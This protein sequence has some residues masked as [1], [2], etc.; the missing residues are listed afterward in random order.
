MPARKTLLYPLV[1]FPGDMYSNFDN[2]KKHMGCFTII[3]LNEQYCK[4]CDLTF[5][6]DTIAVSVREEFLSYVISKI[7]NNIQDKPG[8]RSYGVRIGNA[9]I[10]ICQTGDKVEGHAFEYLVRV[11]KLEPGDPGYR[12]DQEVPATSE[13]SEPAEE[14][15]ADGLD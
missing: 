12:P 6:L 3:I 4:I 9:K 15:P 11:S 1:P 10:W 8:K 2:F 5:K 14:V 13:P 7:L